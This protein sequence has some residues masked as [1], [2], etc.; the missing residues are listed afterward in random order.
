MKKYE[1]LEHTADLGIRVWGRTLPELFINAATGMCELIADVSDT[2]PRELVTVNINAD[3]KDQLLRNWLSELLY[4]FNVK[5]MLLSEFK[6]YKIDDKHI[7]SE[8]R[9]ES[10]DEDKH[11]LR[12]ELKAVTFH[13]LHIEKKQGLLTTEIIFDV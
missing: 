1:L 5:S 12:H 4:Y 8:A 3:D 2:I 9:G 13:R 10:I 7:K 6:I 11:Q